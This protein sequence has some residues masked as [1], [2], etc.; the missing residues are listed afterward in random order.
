[1]TQV[2]QLDLEVFNEPVRLT[3]EV[4]RIEVFESIGYWLNA[5]APKSTFSGGSLYRFLVYFSDG[6]VGLGSYADVQAVLLFCGQEM[7]A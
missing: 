4:H 3:P 1:M 7:I 5:P 2:V 6:R